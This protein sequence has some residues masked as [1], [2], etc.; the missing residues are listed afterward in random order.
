MMLRPGN[1]EIVERLIALCL[2]IRTIDSDGQRPPGNAGR[3]SFVLR[4]GL[5]H[6]GR[7]FEVGVEI[8][9]PFAAWGW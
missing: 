9:F 5:R 4:C 8:H 2:K 1:R 7:C 3:A 6:A